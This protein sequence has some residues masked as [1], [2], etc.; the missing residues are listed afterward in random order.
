AE[1]I[2][3]GSKKDN[4][5]E[6][7][8]TG[9]CGP[10]S[11]IHVDLRPEEEKS[12]TPG[13]DMINKGHPLVIELW[14]L[15]FIEFNRRSDGK[16]EQLPSRHV[17]TGMG[18]ERLTM[19]LQ[20]KKSN[21]DTDLFTPVIRHT[22]EISGI[23]YGTSEASDVAMRVIAD[24]LRAV[25]FAIADGQLPSN[26]RAGYVIR[27]IL[28]RA[29]RYGFTHLNIKEPFMFMLVPTLSGKMG[30]VFPEILAQEELIRKVIHEEEQTFLRT[31]SAGIRKF[32]QYVESHQKEKQIDGAFAFDLFDTYGFPVDLTRLMARE[33]GWEVDMNGFREGLEMQKN[34]SREAASVS[35]GDWIIL[36]PAHQATEFV[37]Y[38][39]LQADVAIVKYRKIATKKG[40][41]WQV[42]LDVTPFYA[43][44]GGQV[45]DRGYLDK[46]GR[47]FPVLDVVKEHEQIVHILNEMPEIP[48]GTFHARVDA[49][50]RILTANNHTATHLMHAA[51]R[52]VLGTHVE[53]KGSY[54]DEN[55]LR[56]DFSHYSKLTEEEIEKIE[57]KV[58]RKIRENIPLEEYRGMPLE[59]A[60]A[61]G[62]M[63][64][65]G[66]K[67]GDEVRVVQ[68]GNDY[69]VELCGGTHVSRTGQ[70]GM[71]KIIS[72]TAIAA[73]IR[74]VEAVTALGAEQFINEQL[75]VI[76]GLK[77]IFK[78]QKDILKGVEGL[79]QRISE[80]ELEV[81][82]LLREKS[83]RIARELI[84]QAEVAGSIRFTAARVD[85]GPD[86]IREMAMGIRS[87]EKELVLLLATVREGK[88]HLGLLITDD[89]IKSKGWDA[90]VIIR[91]LAGEI[92]GGGGGQAWYSSAGGKN[93]GGIE[94]AFQRV[95]EI[96]NFG[97]K[98]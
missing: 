70:I 23:R 82:D 40:E 27:R 59:K 3:P 43:E 68:F 88:A 94:S 50:K 37:G 25:V 73:G 39:T 31:L 66:E 65:F 11:E 64:L 76:K 44:S 14:N 63:A 81:S 18:F 28:R 49:E 52:Q 84:L 29:V 46:D 30:D 10:C 15:V 34:R 91:D 72:E 62:A 17:D 53:Q 8:E 21:Y 89:L 9:P 93:P 58:N 26:V 95:R 98:S 12:Q 96:L 32:E 4:F 13:R 56:F 77:D 16:L 80:L 36:N 6:M 75:S 61:M 86:Q 60:F 97:R 45:G 7:G 51:L 24:H 85:L 90:S 35:A 41:Y 87:R 54:V 55:R 22:E 74:R 33:I 92:G 5:W 20:G 67:Y 78:S 42:I 1:R 48:S 19:V 47:Q 2:L 79:K 71:F 57:E 38:E 69:S 83:D